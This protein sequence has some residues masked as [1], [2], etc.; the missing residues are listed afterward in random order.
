MLMLPFLSA[1]YTLTSFSLTEGAESSPSIEE[2]DH[3]VHERMM[4][5][6]LNFNLDLGPGYTHT[7]YSGRSEPTQPFHQ[8]SDVDTTYLKALSSLQ[9]F[10]KLGASGSIKY[11][12]R[13]DKVATTDDNI[14]QLPNE[15]LSESRSL[16]N[17]P[18]GSTEASVFIGIHHLFGGF[19]L[20][21]QL[22]YLEINLGKD[23]KS[24]DRHQ[25]LVLKYS[26]NL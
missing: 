26:S 13:A 2:L 8:F 6:L 10:W 9:L 22:Y 14:E 11:I 19:G 5:S 16:A 12:V 25:G 3:W 17:L 4:F 23:G 20:G 1:H 24:I 15:S 7:K 18:K 21:W